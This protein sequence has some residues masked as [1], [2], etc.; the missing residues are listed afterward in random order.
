MA[1]GL[2]LLIALVHL[3]LLPL[4]G[5]DLAKAVGDFLTH[6]ARPSMVALLVWIYALATGQGLVARCLRS[7]FLLKYLAP[8]SYAMFLFHFPLAVY[9]CLLFPSANVWYE[10]TQRNGVYIGLGHWWL[11]FAI[12]PLTVLVAMLAQHVLND[13][14]TAG[15]LRCLESCGCCGGSAAPGTEETTL[16][17]VV[18]CIHGLS[19]AEVDGGWLLADCGL[20]SFGTAAL[21][22]VLRARIPDVR[23]TAVQIYQLE[24][25]GELAERIDRDRG[26]AGSCDSGCST[27][28]PS[29]D[30]SGSRGLLQTH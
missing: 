10:D 30:D 26:R 20:D 29:D 24:T 18:Q 28:V 6:S 11:Y 23:L 9:V 25:V 16:G 17:C 15:F 22:G 7:G 1:D 14:L 2:T 27:C 8:A 12:A 5:A 4:M 13:P 19:G 21:L 3:V